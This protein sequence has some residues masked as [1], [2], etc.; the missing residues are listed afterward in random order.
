[1]IVIASIEN[2]IC[3]C[4]K[5]TAKI[6]ILVSCFYKIITANIGGFLLFTN[7]LYYSLCEKK[8]RRK[9]NNLVKHFIITIIIF[10]ITIIITRLIEISALRTLIVHPRSFH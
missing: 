7:C 10:F 6:I 1:M 4:E 9:V 8:K 2:E 3:K 5:N